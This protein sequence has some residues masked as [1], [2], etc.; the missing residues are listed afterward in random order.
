MRA[1]AVDDWLVDAEGESSMSYSQCV[2]CCQ[3]SAQHFD[4]DRYFNAIFEVVDI[5]CDTVRLQQ[6]C[7]GGEWEDDR[8]MSGSTA[9]AWSK[10][11]RYLS[12]CYIHISALDAIYISV[13]I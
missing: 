8:W 13:C 11:Q 3:N 7:S 1:E 10:Y 12:S 6:C 9:A 4:R 2:L 5:W